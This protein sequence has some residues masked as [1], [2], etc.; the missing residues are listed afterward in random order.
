LKAR[1]TVLAAAVF[2]AAGLGA[3]AMLL[4]GGASGGACSRELVVFH[5]GSLSVPLRRV[6][7]LFMAR[8]P[9]VMVRAEAAG[10]RECARKIADLGRRCDV[11]G[12]ADPEVVES[13]LMPDLAA[14][15][16]RF[17]ANWMVVA[18][19]DR[20][21]MAGRVSAQNWP[22]VLLRGDVR[23]GRSDPNT[24]PC[25]YR[26]LMLFHL[27]E[28]HYGMPGLAAR[29]EK[30]GGGRFIRPKETDLLALLE[31][32]EIDYAFI[33]RSVARQHGLRY[34]E[35][36]DEVNLGA[37]GFGALYA[38][39][40]VRLTGRRPGETILRRGAPIVYSVTI[41]KNAPH[42]RLAEQYVALLL[43]AEG[44]RIMGECGQAPLVPPRAGE[45]DAAPEGLRSLLRRREGEHGG[46]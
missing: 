3:G 36:P 46:R 33:Y 25:G 35:L 21:R 6:S 27:A 26:T 1:L 15:N 5:A 18:Y 37:P 34:I 17:A 2:V 40:Q 7:E 4:R 43:S 32:G 8:H 11:F 44:R 16:I 45:G 30:K 38:T 22:E 31:T 23:F 39:A 19:T 10:S 41:P 14:F 20:S 28:R 29:L 13:L 9:D 12:S 24:D 42:P